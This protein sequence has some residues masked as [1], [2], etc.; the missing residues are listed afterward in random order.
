MKYVQSFGIIIFIGGLIYFYNQRMGH[1]TQSAEFSSNT[2]VKINSGVAGSSVNSSAQPDSVRA[3]SLDSQINNETLQ[4]PA[5]EALRESLREKKS[6]EYWDLGGFQEGEGQWIISGS[7]LIISKDKSKEQIFQL[8]GEVL[9]GLNSN[10]KP[11][12]EIDDPVETDSLSIYSV[13]FSYNDI[14]VRDAGLK[15]VVDKNSGGVN[16]IQMDS[17][18]LTEVE[19]SIRLSKNEV[20]SEIRNNLGRQVNSVQVFEKPVIDVNNEGLGRNV[21]VA[22]VETV[23]PKDKKQYFIDAETGKVIHKNSI[24]IRN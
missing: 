3:K 6:N 13:G 15:V 12:S 17:I 18:F 1:N 21:W 5:L 16:V 8:A 24:I 10:Q 11:I 19:N 7:G 2:N 22:I 9:A 23:D 4:G 20:E 14:K